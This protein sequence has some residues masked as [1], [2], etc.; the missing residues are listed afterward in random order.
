M[1]RHLESPKF[2]RAGGQQARETGWAMRGLIAVYI[3]T[4]KEN[5]SMRVAELP[6]NLSSGRKSGVLFSRLIPRI[7]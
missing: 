7:R 5:T 4:R 1:I 6:S 3:E 2:S